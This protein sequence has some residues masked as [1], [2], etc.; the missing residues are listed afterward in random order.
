[1]LCALLGCGAGARPDVDLPAPP[2]RP[3]G[4]EL[5]RADRALQLAAEL[6]AGGDRCVI[7]R[8][9]RVPRMRRGLLARVSQAEPMAWL[10]ELDVRAYAS[11]RRDDHDGPSAQV[12]LLW[13]GAPRQRVRE[14]L[15][16]RSGLVLHWEEDASCEPGECPVRARFASEHVVRIERGAL[17]PA[18]RS[19]V[20][21]QCRKMAARSPGAA[22]VSAARSRNFGVFALTGLPVRASS[23]IR[24]SRGGLHVE[25]ID[26]MRTPDE[27]ERALV[28]GI[29]PEVFFPGQGALGKDMRRTRVRAAVHT[30]FDLLWA[31]LELVRDDEER[32]ALAARE[33]DALASVGPPQGVFPAVREDVLAEL[34]YRLELVARASGEP[35]RVQAQA[36]RRLLEAALARD[37]DD[38]GLALLLTEFLLSEQ[39]EPGPAR[40][41][42]QRFAERA[43][44]HRNWAMFERHAAALTS[45]A[46]LAEVLVRQG[47]TDR[48]YARTAAHEIAAQVQQGVSFERAERAVLEAVR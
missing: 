27:A 17:V 12:T 24:A 19:G 8:P 28:E 39:G 33:A 3:S 10:T 23:E 13:V 14:V 11:V 22:E 41:L 42:V 20:E 40:A 46:A 38:E 2:S 9:A 18:S 15:D 7:A 1:M 25:R 5:Q 31:D 48:R 36:A 6:P 29:A 35:R 47:L 4:A 32:L 30:R 16:A 37:P 45:A 44:A 34:G 26:R 43:G 21:A